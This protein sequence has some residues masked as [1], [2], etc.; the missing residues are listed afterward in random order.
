MKRLFLLFAALL[1]LASAR[2][3]FAYDYPDG[4]RE[5]VEA[6]WARQEATAERAIDQG[7][8]LKALAGRAAALL[9]R[10]EEDEAIDENRAAALRQEI[11]KVNGTDFDKLSVEKIRRE[12]LALRWSV[13]EAAFDNPLVKDIPIVFLKANRY[14]WQLIHEYLSYYYSHTNMRGGELMLLENPGFSFDA[15][16]LTGGKLPRGVFETPS[17]SFDGKTL[18]F[19]FAD[20]T[21]VVPEDAPEETL[22]VIINRGYDHEIENYLAR[23]D[24]KFH[25][26]KLD[27]ADGKIEQLTDG[28]DDD[29]DPA[30]L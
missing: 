2:V 29:F 13:R 19:A 27:L 10:L 11:D 12:Y 30:E 26:Y 22:Q 17:L 5:T 9:D 6:D 24:G 4:F 16:S 20:F 14:V 21:N 8:A 18:Y 1:A 25:L 28:P 7:E 3:L 15:R 23:S